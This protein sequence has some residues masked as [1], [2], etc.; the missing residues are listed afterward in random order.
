MPEGSRGQ[1][2]TGRRDVGVWLPCPLWKSVSVSV[3]RSPWNR[4]TPS[5]PQGLM[6]KLPLA[7]SFHLFPL[8]IPIPLL[9]PVQFFNY[10]FTTFVSLDWLGLFET[11]TVADSDKVNNIPSQLCNFPSPNFF[12][13][14]LAPCKHRDRCPWHITL[15]KTICLLGYDFKNQEFWSREHPRRVAHFEQMRFHFVNFVVTNTF[16][17]TKFMKL[18]ECL[19]FVNGRLFRD[20]RADEMQSCSRNDFFTNGVP[21]NPTQ[22]ECFGGTVVFVCFW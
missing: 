6:R 11:G 9:L 21:Y 16:R 3:D 12:K 14:S 20:F 19:H 22:A 17:G 5:I 8:S 4:D 7:S 10:H 13:D 15:P 18:I 1:C 2:P